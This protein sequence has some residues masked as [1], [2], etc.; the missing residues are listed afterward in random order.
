[1]VNLTLMISG[2]GRFVALTVGI[3]LSA[4][5]AY[6]AAEWWGNRGAPPEVEAVGTP[7]SIEPRVRYS[8][9]SDL[10][11][12]DFTS[13]RIDRSDDENLSIYG[14]PCVMQGEPNT[15]QIDVECSLPGTCE[16][17]YSLVGRFDGEGSFTGT[18]SV[19]FWPDGPMATCVDCETQ[20]WRLRGSAR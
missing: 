13:I 18:F 14:G 11:H 3:A 5:C 12:L 16:E 19:E 6:A 2:R 15:E 8:C 10:V 20:S 1:M 7:Y 4:I 9:A 17:I